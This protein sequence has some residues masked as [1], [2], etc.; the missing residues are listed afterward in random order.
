MVGSRQFRGGTALGIGLS[1][2]GW[3]IR[4]YAGPGPDCA[5]PAAWM[6]SFAAVAVVAVTSVCMALGPTRPSGQVLRGRS[7]T[8]DA[9]RPYVDWRAVC[10][11]RAGRR[12]TETLDR[13]AADVAS[14]VFAAAMAAT[15]LR[16]VAKALE[17]GR[18]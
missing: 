17:V 4:H 11:A 14:A 12:M 7:W 5:A 10:T 8:L 6:L 1:A 2:T 13:E 9:V 15:L 18:P 3:A 16:D